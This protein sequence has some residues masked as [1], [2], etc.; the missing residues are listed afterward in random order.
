MSN[1]L[2]PED[3]QKLLLEKAQEMYPEG[4]DIVYGDGDSIMINPK[5]K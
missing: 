1:K 2:S 3:I 5:T 4:F